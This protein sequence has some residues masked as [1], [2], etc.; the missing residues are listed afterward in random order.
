MTRS[1]PNPNLVEF[2][3]EIERTLRQ[4]RR[5]RR[6]L[7]DTSFANNSV[8]DS[9]VPNTSPNFTNNF[10]FAD[11]MANRT[12][13]ELAA[14]DVNYQPLAIQYLE[15]EADFELKSGLILCYPS[16]MV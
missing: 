13:K 3:P 6:R 5:S 1:D 4:I 7:F 14:P 2:D 10:V 12:L 11:N 8:Y 16:S 9:P 15:L